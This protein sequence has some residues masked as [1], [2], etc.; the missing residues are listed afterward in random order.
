MMLLPGSYI[1]FDCPRAVPSEYTSEPM[2]V[3][4]RF[5]LRSLYRA[6]F[7]STE[8]RGLESKDHPARTADDPATQVRSCDSQ[9]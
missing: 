3:N 1:G 7:G 4:V 5:S 6:M 8:S 2:K 9:C